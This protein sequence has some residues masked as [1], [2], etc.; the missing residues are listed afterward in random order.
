MIRTCSQEVG[1]TSCMHVEK[2][3]VG[4]Y[5]PVSCL[6]VVLA[7]SPSMFL[8]LPSAS[9]AS[10]RVLSG[11]QWQ[12]VLRPC[13]AA[14]SPPRQREGPVAHRSLPPSCPHR[15]LA[16]LRA[17][18]PGC[19]LPRCCCLL[20]LRHQTHARSGASHPQLRRP[21]LHRQGSAWGEEKRGEREGKGS[22]NRSLP[23]S[24]LHLEVLFSAYAGHLLRVS[25]VL[26]LTVVK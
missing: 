25:H 13:A 23:L 22:V 3:Q 16:D 26:S 15:P 24:C 7:L 9:S 2:L 17:W 6:V 19:C 21:P 5:S 10:A 11:W 8:A 18:G 20:L 12:S 14:S 4:T 1:A